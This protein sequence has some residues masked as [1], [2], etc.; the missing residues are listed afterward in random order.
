MNIEELAPDT[1]G[2]VGAGANINT[3]FTQP[4]ANTLASALAQASTQNAAATAAAIAAAAQ[5]MASRPRLCSYIYFARPPVS[6]APFGPGTARHG[7]R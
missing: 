7:R 2:H 1:W 5:R 6:P 3:E 4:V